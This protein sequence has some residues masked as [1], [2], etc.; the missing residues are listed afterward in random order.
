MTATE[1]W[2]GGHCI[3]E[4]SIYIFPVLW[5]TALDI[6]IILFSVSQFSLSAIQISYTY[7][8]TSSSKWSHKPKSNLYYQHV[9]GF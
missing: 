1:S 4:L 6:Y 5:S 7:F 9:L 2:P 8:L 3:L